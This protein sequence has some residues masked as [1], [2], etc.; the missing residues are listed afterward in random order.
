MAEAG[1]ALCDDGQ[2]E[3]VEGASHWLHLERP[4]PTNGRIIQFL[5]G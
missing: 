3:F 2:L 1:L 5:K 4:G